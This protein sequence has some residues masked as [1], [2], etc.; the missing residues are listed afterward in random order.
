[1]KRKYYLLAGLFVFVAIAWFWVGQGGKMKAEGNYHF[2]VDSNPLS[3]EYEM[4]RSSI[5]VTVMNEANQAPATKEFQWELSPGTALTFDPNGGIQASTGLQQNLNPRTIYARAAGEE[6]L[7]VRIHEINGADTEDQFVTA[8]IKVGYFIEETSD[9]AEIIENEKSALVL[10]KDDD[11]KTLKFIFD[12]PDKNSV[13]W[14]TSDTNVIFMKGSVDGKENNTGEIVAVGTGKAVITANYVDQDSVSH[15]DSI[16]VYVGPQ[17]SINNEILSS[18]EPRW[19]TKGD[20]IGTGVKSDGATSIK[21]KVSWEATIINTGYPDD[22]KSVDIFDW[23]P[24]SSNLI[25]KAKAGMYRVT[26]CTAGN[27]IKRNQKLLN[28]FTIT[29][30][31]TN[32]YPESTSTEITS[33]QVGDTL[34]FAAKYNME[35][36]EFERCFNAT[37]VSGGSIKVAGKNGTFLGETEGK[38]EVSLEVRDASRLAALMGVSVDKIQ[39]SYRTEVFVYDGFKLDYSSIKIAVGDTYP[40]KTVYGGTGGPVVWKSA[41]E[42]FVTVDKDTGEIKGIRETTGDGVNVT[43]EMTLN[44]GRVLRASCKVIV[45]KT[46]TKIDLTP[47]KLEMKVGDLQPVKATFDS[48]ITTIR[49]LRWLISDEKVATV[50]VVDDTTVMVEGKSS[51]TAILTALNGENF[52][53]GYCEVKVLA[54]ITGLSL[55]EGEIMEV[56]LSQEIIRFHPKIEPADANEGLVWSSTN[57]SVAEI[58]QNGIATLKGAGTTKIIVKPEWNT[59]LM[60]TCELTVIETAKS[61]SITPASFELEVKETKQLTANQGTGKSTITWTSL[62]TKIATVGKDDG[63][64]TAVAA[65]QTYIVANTENGY[66]ATSLVTV[67]QKA[68]GVQLDTYNITV[69]VGES[70]KVT[71]TAN[72]TTSTEKKFTWTSKDPSIATVKDDGTVTGVSAGSTIVLIKT[73]GG[74]VT[75]LYVTVKDKATGMELNY[76]T[77]TVAKGSSF[78]LKPIFTP[79]NVT[80]KKVAWKSSNDGIAKISDK[81]KVTG[82]KGGSVIITAVSE[83]GG[84]VATCLVTVVQAVTK[85]KL[86]YS[87]YKLG[88]GKSFTLKA[89]VT[90]NTSS[91][92]KVKWTSSNTRVAQVSSSGKVT[93]KKV[94]SCTITATATD[95]SKKKASCK[96]TVV[97]QVTSI[98]LNKSYLTLVVGKNFQMKATIKPS[99]ATYKTPSWK[100]SNDAVAKITSTG[101]VRGIAAGSCD[102]I[103]TAK[104]NSKKSASCYVEVIEPIPASNILVADKNMVMIRGES[105]TVSYTMVPSNST[106]T[107]KFA[108]GNKN[109]ATVSSTGRV[110]AR[111]AGA[112]TITITTSS[113][114]Q[115]DIQ[116]QVIGLNKTSI[117]MEQYDTEVLYV[118]GATS[119]ITWYSANPSVATVVNGKV[120]GRKA[121]TTYIYAK[122]AGITL[123]C[124]VTV[125][126]IR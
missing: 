27:E 22:N 99:N 94:G 122:I 1:M 56:K 18:T 54:P 32:F 16:T 46:A 103:A 58:D 55:E 101:L 34:D 5:S 19:V 85:V 88:L 98:K 7:T 44:D 51:G 73:K 81:G 26:L 6:T 47:S 97:R 93:G 91:N 9:F 77:K 50:K 78:T 109:I 14:T 106:D 68:T 107:V 20:P 39:K 8:S 80:N 74:E 114:K 111:R 75:Y 28:S 12:L 83:D 24:T 30:R 40:L 79:T 17:A 125:R 62:D 110:Y 102:I 86:N 104:D 36:A 95:G 35:Q 45:V 37:I 66:V 112:T 21:E 70:Y 33:L 64:V 43:A 25:V 41:D 84:H 59:L 87:S 105:Q 71:A 52:V 115:I 96:V 120:V 42:S 118:D 117:T 113:G 10:Y 126:N 3:G 76:A 72:P 100:S 116:L 60:V 31:P 123:G 57:T 69:N 65:G 61:L 92:K 124:R 15:S 29:V 63:K 67:T 53:A 2:V 82:V 23:S 89:T 11:T 49:D 38:T 90:S 119:G 4:R 13:K 48:G 121:G 108:S